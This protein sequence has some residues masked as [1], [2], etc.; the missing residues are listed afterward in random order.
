MQTF[1][2]MFQRTGDFK[3]VN[4]LARLFGLFNEQVVANWCNCEQAEFSNLGRPTI[5]VVGGTSRA[6]LD[7]LLEARHG[8]ERGK[9]FVAEMK[10]WL[11]A[12]QGRHLRLT[13]MDFVESFRNEN[14]SFQTFLDFAKAPDTFRIAV[15]GRVRGS[16][17]DGAILIWSAVT[18][19]GRTAALTHGIRR[20]LSVEEMLRDLNERKCEPWTKCVAAYAEWSGELFRYLAGK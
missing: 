20:V 8:T 19:D 1:E 9:V 2:E 13:S 6:I 14:K 10:C 15:N 11:A 12:E 17:S 4:F 5:R 18:P 16:S 7:F 3:R